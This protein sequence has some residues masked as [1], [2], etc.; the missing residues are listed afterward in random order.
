MPTTLRRLTEG[1]IFDRSM[2]SDELRSGGMQSAVRG[3]IFDVSIEKTK[4]LTSLLC[5]A[6]DRPIL[7]SF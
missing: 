7:L 6:S 1:A 4:S 2:R 5:P 3:P